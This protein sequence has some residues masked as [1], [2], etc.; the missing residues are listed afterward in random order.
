[1]GVGEYGGASYKGNSLRDLPGVT[2]A[3]LPLMK[4]K[5]ESLGFRVRVVSNPTR[6]EAEKEVDAF[7][8]RIRERPGV[9]LFY[10]SG[11]GGEHRG[12]NFL[13]PRRA[14]IGSAADFEEE[15]LN[16][17]RVLNG[18]EES[19][20]VV[21]L[22]FLDCYREDL[23]KSVGGAQLAPLK[24]RGSFVGFATR[25]GDLADSEGKGSPYTRYLLRHLGT[26]GV[27]LADMYA[28]VIAD[29]KSHLKR[30]LGEERRPGFYSEL[31][32]PFYFVPGK[33]GDSGDGG[34]PASRA[35]PA[36]ST[37]GVGA[38]ELEQ[39]GVGR[40]AQVSVSG[41]V[42]LR[43][44]YCPPGKFTMGSVSGAKFKGDRS[45]VEPVSVQISRGFW[46]AETEMTQT[47]WVAVMGANPSSGEGDNLPVERVSWMDIRKML[48]ALNAAV[49]LPEGWRFE[50]PTEAQWEYAC[51]AGRRTRFMNGERFTPDD[52][53]YY[54][55]AQ[56]TIPVKSFPP[57]AWGLYD[58]DGNVCEWCVDWYR[59]KLLG[60]SDPEQRT[61]GVF[62][63]T[64]GGCF[65]SA[66]QFCEPSSRGHAKPSERSPCIGLRLVLVPSR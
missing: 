22:V 39:G 46:M 3:D 14:S 10:F 19:G 4:E 42:Q 26:P 54:L 43:F 63:M 31:D 25:N 28:A 66:E 7:S 12:K 5:L 55:S 40:V 1:M 58:M 34:A 20:S 48:A 56:G 53:N 32:A 51:R 29:V 50:L 38:G 23:G 65:I 18:M 6:K 9:S 44:C 33:S 27:S 2:N 57:N 13:I 52:A 16:P 30:V 8:A 45:Y 47:Q 24:A 49:R 36:G 17:Q 35:Q 62:K 37:G 21:N 60:G 64:R 15:A 61:G 59:E 41:G 11:H